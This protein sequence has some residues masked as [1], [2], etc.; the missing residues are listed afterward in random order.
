MTPSRRMRS[1]V[2]RR[3][4]RSMGSPGFR[5]AIAAALKAQGM[6]TVS[7]IRSDEALA[8]V[9]VDETELRDCSCRGDCD[10]SSAF[11]RARGMIKC[12]IWL[13]R[14]IWILSIITPSVPANAGALCS[15]TIGF[16]HPRSLDAPQHS[17]ITVGQHFTQTGIH[18]S[19]HHQA[20][21][22]LV[23]PKSCLRS[24]QM[25]EIGQQWSGRVEP[26]A[27]VADCRKANAMAR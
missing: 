8:R 1:P 15:D 14:C 26:D 25:G 4:N 10:R 21:L 24:G 23:R 22:S 18:P 16:F 9:L 7:R 17:D 20:A 3:V 19:R 13:I 12:L 11:Y 2:S 27:I 6:V 5:S